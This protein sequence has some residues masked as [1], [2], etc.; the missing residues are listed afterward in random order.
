MAPNLVKLALV[1]IHDTISSNELT[2]SQ[3]VEAA[4]C[5]KRAITPSSMALQSSSAFKEQMPSK[6]LERGAA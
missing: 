2:T 5:S 1:L 4:G 6:T 3:M